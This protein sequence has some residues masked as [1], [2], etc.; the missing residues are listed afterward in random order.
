M[1]ETERSGSRRAETACF[2][3][4][5]ISLESV[6]ILFVEDGDSLWQDFVAAFV[7]AVIARTVTWLA[8]GRRRRARP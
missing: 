4:I 6:A 1:A 3:V 2:L 8:F 5:F 7:V